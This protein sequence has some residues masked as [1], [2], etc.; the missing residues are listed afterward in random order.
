MAFDL[1]RRGRAFLVHLGGSLLMA[2]GALALVYGVWYP[3]PLAR[4]VGVSAIVLLMLAVDAV[5]G[6]VLT[7]VVYQVGKKSLRF[8]L[9]VI[10]AIQLLAFGFGLHTIAQGR[11]AW[12]VF[13]ADRFDV[14]QA[15]EL[16]LRY[17]ADARPVYRSAPWGGPRWVASVNPEDLGKRNQLILES[18]EGGPDLPQ[19]IDLYRPLDGE[20]V[21]LRARAK[22]LDELKKFNSPQEVGVALAEWPQAD[23]WLPLMSRAQAMVVLL[24]KARAEPVAI[25]DLRPWL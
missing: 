7:F 8:D 10:V 18:A 12:L 14:A 16:D 17:L 1:R 6:P 2:F 23:A 11:P 22:P 3:A 4:A 20:A 15:N 25:V 9:A 19:R 13:N 5:L 24:D 21:Q